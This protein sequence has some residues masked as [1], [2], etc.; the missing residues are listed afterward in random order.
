VNHNHPTAAI[1]PLCQGGEKMA[2]F[3][4]QATDS[5]G[6]SPSAMVRLLDCPTPRLLD[7][8]FAAAR[9]QRAR[10]FG[11]QVFLYGFL[12]ISTHCRNRCSFCLYRKNNSHAI[13]YRK[14]LAEIVESARQLA[15][16]GVHLIDVTAGEDPCF[17][18]GDNAFGSV[19]NTLQTI[20]QATDLPLMA[21]VG[22][23]ADRNLERLA[24][25]GVDWYA[26][27]QETHNRQLFEQLRVGQS[28]QARCR[29][30]VAAKA[31][32]LLVEEGVLCG[33]G[34]TSSDLVHSFGAMSRLKVDQVRAMSF[35]PQPG[36]PL[37][38][39]PA[40]SHLRELMTIALM[41]LAF[42]HLLIPASLD[43]DG[44][45][46]LQQRLD[47]GANVVTSVVPPGQ[48]LAGVAQQD[49]DIEDGRRSVD[50]ILR[51]LERCGLVPATHAQY[52]S[53]IHQR[54]GMACIPLGSL[55]RAC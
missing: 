54:K 4:D 17:H 44:L 36:T 19:I 3:L 33:V 32:G 52:R 49:L 55:A 13:R 24:T 1:A 38:D 35:V 9:R 5:I 53:W 34:E 8:L 50:G 40:A 43:V 42:P 41:R 12:Y 27:Y 21:S 30:K 48:G 14:T 25:A 20:K 51:T 28:Y 23:V 6:L 11:D 26:C 39:L 18:Q 2:A 16:S 37:K 7:K 47:A 15:R 10:H 31:K 22:V 46:G 45:A 29:S